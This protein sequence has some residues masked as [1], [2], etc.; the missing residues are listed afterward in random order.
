MQ[1]DDRRIGLVRLLTIALRVLAVLEGVVHQYLSQQQEALAGLF[2]GNPK[3][4]TAQ[5][6]TERL[7]EAFGEIT[8]TIV[9]AP[10]FA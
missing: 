6:T 9:S 7:L 1:R 8:L 4:Q 2:V 10:G 3:R 5:P